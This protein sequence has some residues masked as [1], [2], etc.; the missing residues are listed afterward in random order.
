M[1]RFAGAFILVLWVAGCKTPNPVH[2]VQMERFSGLG[3]YH[4]T[5]LMETKTEVLEDGRRIITEMPVYTTTT[6]TFSDG[7]A[8]VVKAPIRLGIER[9]SPIVITPKGGS[10]GL[11]A[12]LIR[13]GASLYAIDRIADTAD[14]AA[15]AN[16]TLA[17]S[18]GAL[19]Q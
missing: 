8:V 7:R 13:E 6:T 12:T 9:N 18:V 11:G 16:N 15:A 2:T 4:L 3:K 10:N 14:A 17:E 5:A 19:S 1:K